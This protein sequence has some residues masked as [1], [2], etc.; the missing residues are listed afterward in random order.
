MV[1]IKAIPFS[2]T[3]DRVKRKIGIANGKYKFDDNFF[4]ELDNEII[5]MFGV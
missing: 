4:D 5:N 3:T 2:I 1:N